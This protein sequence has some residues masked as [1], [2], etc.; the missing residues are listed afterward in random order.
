MTRRSWPIQYKTDLMFWGV[1]VCVCVCVCFL[2][3]FVLAYFCILVFFF[4]LECF[5]VFLLF[6]AVYLEVCFW[7]RGEGGEEGEREE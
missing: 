2:F 1:C 4:L 5:A 6:F 7:G 3:C